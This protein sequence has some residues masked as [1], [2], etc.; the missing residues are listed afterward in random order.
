MV[1]ARNLAILHAVA[2]SRLL[3]ATDCSHLGLESAVIFIH[4]AG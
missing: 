4:G 1:Q 2:G 3:F